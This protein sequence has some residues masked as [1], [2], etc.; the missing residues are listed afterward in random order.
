M[1]FGQLIEYNVCIVIVCF[2]GCDIIN[3]EINLFSNQHVFLHDQKV[4]KK[5]KYL[6]NDQSF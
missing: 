4:K 2:Q 6:E 1:K 5:V 3:F